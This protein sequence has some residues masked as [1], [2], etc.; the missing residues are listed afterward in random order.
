[1]LCDDLEWWEG[2]TGAMK[3]RVGGRGYVYTYSWSTLLY[4]RNLHN[5]V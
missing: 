2:G 3:G 5:I 1:M 4:T